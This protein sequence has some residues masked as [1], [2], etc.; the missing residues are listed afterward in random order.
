MLSLFFIAAP[1]PCP[2]SAVASGS[3][4]CFC[5]LQRQNCLLPNSI[6]SQAAY[7]NCERNNLL[8]I[9]MLNREDAFV[10]GYFSFSEDQKKSE[11][12]SEMLTGAKK[13]ELPL[14]ILYG[15]CIILNE[16][17]KYTA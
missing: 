5:K 2:F 8:C 9:F 10:A 17:I 16:E 6:C 14:Q 7:E 11:M 12:C 1:C 13:T 4:Q 3:V 15:M